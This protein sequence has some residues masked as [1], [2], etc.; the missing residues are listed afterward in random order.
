[1]KQESEPEPINQ[2]ATDDNHEVCIAAG[3]INLLTD[4]LNDLQVRLTKLEAQMSSLDNQDNHFEKVYT[5]E[6]KLIIQQ[7]NTINKQIEHLSESLRSTP[8][9]KL[10]KIFNC[11]CGSTGTVALNIKCTTCGKEN[12][13]GYWPQKKIS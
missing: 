9:F 10:G 11:S 5:S 4:Q 7:V 2:N 12:W 8:D 13:W 3:Q 1:M 6:F